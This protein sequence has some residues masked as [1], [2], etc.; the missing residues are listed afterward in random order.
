MKKFIC[1]VV[2]FLLFFT[3][4]TAQDLVTSTEA[5]TGVLT[6]VVISAQTSNSSGPFV[7]GFDNTGDKVTVNVTVPV[8]ANYNMG[9]TYRGIYGA[10][11][12]DIYANN[13]FVANVNFP[14]TTDFVELG[15]GSVFLNAGVNTL[16]LQKNWGY[17]DVDKFSIYTVAPNVFNIVTSLID[18]QATAE[19]KNLYSFML[20]Q[21]GKRIISGQT[22]GYYDEL[23]TIAGKSPLLRSW[24]MSSYSPQYAYK[25]RF[26]I[27]R[28]R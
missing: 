4:L 13:I 21:F 15:A 26:C 9:I 5:E 27:W 12:Q 18:A 23:K 10:K 24:D 7:T 11:V 6:G 14:K 22:D 28:S 8:A 19:A 17:M 3:S 2:M 16:T 20:S 1:S 25:W